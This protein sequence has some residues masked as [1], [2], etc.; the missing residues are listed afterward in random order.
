MPGELLRTMAAP[1]VSKGKLSQ[2]PADMYLIVHFPC[3]ET[4]KTIAN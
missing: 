2:R 3:H 4:L 1:T